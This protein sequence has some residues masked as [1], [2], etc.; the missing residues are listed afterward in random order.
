MDH[1]GSIP[2]CP[3]GVGLSM[4]YKTCLVRF[5]SFVWFINYY[6]MQNLLSAHRVCTQRVETEAVADF[7]ISSI[8]KKNIFPIYG[9][10]LKFRTP[11]EW[12]AHC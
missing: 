1:T 9:L 3:L 7:S 5:T 2:P 10:K 12:D 8:G 6:T 4:S 11:R